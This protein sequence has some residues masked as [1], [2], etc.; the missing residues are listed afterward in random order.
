MFRQ[1]V[2]SC[3]RPRANKLISPNNLC[4]GTGSVQIQPISPGKRAGKGANTYSKRNSL[5]VFSCIRVSANTGPACLLPK[6]KFLNIFPACIGFVPGGIVP[7]GLRGN[8]DNYQS[9]KRDSAKTLT[10]ELLRSSLPSPRKERD[11]ETKGSAFW[12]T[13]VHSRIAA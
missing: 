9:K 3:I 12:G 5:R 13:I 2:F 6:N 8:P 10:R 11:R 4:I 7:L 1:K